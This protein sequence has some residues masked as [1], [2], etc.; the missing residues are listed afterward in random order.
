MTTASLA[1]LGDWTLFGFTRKPETLLKQ[2]LPA[3]LGIEPASIRLGALGYLFFY[4][5]YGDIGESE[6]AIA[7]RLGNAY[8]PS[9]SPLSAQD[10]LRHEILHPDRIDLNQL[11]GNAS[12]ICLSKIEPQFAVYQTLLSA[13]QIHYT[14]FDGGILCADNLRAL[15]SLLGRIEANETAIPM[16]FL[17][18][19]IPGGLTYF[20]G[21]HSLCP[22]ELLVWENDNLRVKLMHDLRSAASDTRWSHADPKASSMLFE[23][24]KRILGTYVSDVQENGARF[25]TLLS[26]GVDS[27]VIQ[28]ALNDRYPSTKT[29]SFSY[30]MLAPSFEAEIR[31]AD[32]ARR[33][34]QT[35]HTV[36]E[37]LP[38]NYL[39][40]LTRTIDT[41]YHP[42]LC[43]ETDPCIL[44]LAEHIQ[45]NARNL[46]FFFAGHGADALFGAP[47]A[48]KILALNL[49]RRLPAARVLLMGTAK[50]I[51]QHA[52]Q[53]ADGLRQIADMLPEL[54]NQNSFRVPA[55]VMNVY[56]DI[57]MARTCF[58]DEALLKALEYRRD[59]VARYL[60]SSSYMEQVH[61]IELLTWDYEAAVFTQQLFLAHRKE[62]LFPFLCEDMLR[63][64]YSFDP[65][66]RYIKDANVKPL[67]KQILV[68]KSLPAIAKN[69]KRGGTFEEDLFAWMKQGPLQERVR[70]IK[71]PS[72]MSQKDLQQ[73]M[74]NP[75]PFLWE[76]LI[77]DIFQERIID[78]HNGKVLNASS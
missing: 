34:L 58:G 16:H 52:P 68:Q 24:L 48:R 49:S 9:L 32:Q 77:W 64:A 39:D 71:Q 33:S 7:I 17:F 18:R 57:N 54:Q 22:G 4:T 26:G 56:T 66:V 23:S 50:L 12:L 27:S 73:L 38:D 19:L 61:T 15:V 14:I 36:V 53:K 70:S 45:A 1:P 44:A 46:R 74:D 60:D 13:L 63:L 41:V 2:Y 59:F 69:P 6:K 8:S 20:K 67:L 62:I 43:V 3:R 11:S 55:N 42:S 31:Y 5:S 35:D 37:I 29:S 28:L 51:Q 78:A 47:I 40:L 75:S 30:S 76:L 10:L 65:S 21:I 25:G 72:F